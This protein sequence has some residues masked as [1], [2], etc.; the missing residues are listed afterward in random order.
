MHG[1][2]R[3]SAARAVYFGPYTSPTMSSNRSRSARAASP[4]DDAAASATVAGEVIE[5][6]RGSGRAPDLDGRKVMVRFVG[7]MTRIPRYLKL[8]WLLMNDP[9]VSRGGKAA[10]GGGLA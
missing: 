5:P 3:T 9:T 1:A 6:K 7:V 4:V 10:L 8:G 2:C